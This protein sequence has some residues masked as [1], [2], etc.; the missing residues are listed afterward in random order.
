MSPSSSLHVEW[1]SNNMTSSHTINSAPFGHHATICQFSAVEDLIMIKPHITSASRVA[2]ATPV[3]TGIN[4]T[5]NKR[6]FHRAC[7]REN[8]LLI[9]ITTTSPRRL[10][11][12]LHKKLIAFADDLGPAVCSVRRRVFAQRD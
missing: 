2:Q 1:L 9:R 10:R 3:T 7:V 11:R 5:T 12:W 8:S 6:L 4:S